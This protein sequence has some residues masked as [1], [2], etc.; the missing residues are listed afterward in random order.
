MMTASYTDTDQGH[1]EVWGAPAS[2]TIFLTLLATTIALNSALMTPLGRGGDAC[3]LG[4]SGGQPTQA[5]APAL[6]SGGGSSPSAHSAPL[7]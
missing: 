2:R 6:V 7:T 5:P 3:G 4:R 1:K